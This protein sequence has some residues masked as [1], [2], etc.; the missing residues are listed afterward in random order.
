MAATAWVEEGSVAVLA[1]KVKVPSEKVEAAAAEA[2]ALEVADA[3][4]E[5]ASPFLA[6]KV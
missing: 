2:A 4:N 5:V 6:A 3:A 1:V